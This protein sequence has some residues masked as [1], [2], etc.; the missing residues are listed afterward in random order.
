MLKVTEDTVEKKTKNLTVYFT[1]KL[2][3]K[4]TLFSVI[5]I[6]EFAGECTQRLGQTETT[7][8]YVTNKLLLSS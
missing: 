5:T 3:T 1:N 2:E 6:Q 7:N 8:N 4:T